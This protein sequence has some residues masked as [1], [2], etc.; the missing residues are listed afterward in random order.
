MFPTGGTNVIPSLS[1]TIDD[2]ITPPVPIGF[3][4][5]YY[6]ATYTSVLIC[7]NGFIQ[8]DIGS[9]PNLSFS[10]P[11]QAFPD[12]AS[13]N[14]IVALN[15]NDLDPNIGGTITYT[16]IGSAPNRIFI[17]TYSNVPIWTYNSSINSGQI[18]LYE[19]TN[20]IEVHSNSINASNTNIYNGTQGIEN[21]TGSSGNTVPGR[22]AGIWQVTS[23]DAFRWT[24]VAQYTAAPLS[25]TITGPTSLCAGQTAN[26][27]LTTTLLPNSFNWSVP[28]TWTASSSSVTTLSST[29]GA[30]GSVSV[31]AT[32]SCGTT[33]PISFSVTALPLPFISIQTVTPAFICSGETMTITAGGGGTYTLFP[34]NIQVPATFTVMPPSTMIYSV[35]GTGTNGCEALNPAQAGVQVY[36]T[37]TITVSSGA[38]CL[39]QSYMFTVTG[40]AQ[41]TYS[42]LFA[43]ITPT[44]PGTYTCDVIGQATNNCVDTARGTLTVNPIPSLTISASRLSM[45][46]KEVITLTVSGATSYTW[47]N[48]TNVATMTISPTTNTVYSVNGANQFSCTNSTSLGITVK[49]CVGIDEKI[50]DTE[51]IGIF[52]NPSGGSFNYRCDDCAGKAFTVYD[53]Q[54]RLIRTFTSETGSGKIDLSDHPAG[55]YL[56]KS[57]GSP[58]VQRLLKE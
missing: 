29:V 40:A 6:C 8:F 11:A 44:I 48:N 54:G 17:A 36:E 26:F 18:V 27:A 55:I 34:G 28:G 19:G 24:P 13:P 42:T 56:L 4:F 39:G 47:A 52:P 50:Y 46:P 58:H 22:S 31:S 1:P 43:S 14:G 51:G 21:P 38:V 9:P 5:D 2:G 41:Y 16:T 57:D 3:S 45:C 49:P 25:A 20:I 35:I 32:F 33:P 7:S 53:A 23:P 30:S 10:N 12:P 37:P 15:M